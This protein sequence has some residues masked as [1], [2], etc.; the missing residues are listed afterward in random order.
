MCYRIS[1]YTMI[2]GKKIG[3]TVISGIVNKC[4][5]TYKT[6][7]S[8]VKNHSGYSMFFKLVWITFRT[9]DAYILRCRLQIFSC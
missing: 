7:S 3:S 5:G 1:A 9:V 6:T 4:S 2:C 8:F